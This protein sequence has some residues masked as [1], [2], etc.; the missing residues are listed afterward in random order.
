MGWRWGRHVL[1]LGTFLES[2]HS[3]EKGRERLKVR[4]CALRE[5]CLFPGSHVLMG[6]V[7]NP[8]RPQSHTP[9]PD[10]QPHLEQT[11]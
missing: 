10:L 6:L 11:V 2:L 1:E 5:T 8:S 9:Y 3:Q 7:Y 4:V